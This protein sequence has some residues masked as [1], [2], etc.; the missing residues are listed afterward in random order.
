MDT[1][2]CV[3]RILGPERDCQESLC[4]SAMRALVCPEGTLVPGALS[5]DALICS[6]REK[7]FKHSMGSCT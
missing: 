3:N 5:S 1:E 4:S 7:H 6:F 2:Q